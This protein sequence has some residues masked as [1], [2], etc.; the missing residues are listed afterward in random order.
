MMQL[1]KLPH[2]SNFDIGLGDFCCIEI[3]PQVRLSVERCLSRLNNMCVGCTGD[4]STWF[5]AGGYC[6]YKAGYTNTYND[7]DLYVYCNGKVNQSQN[8]TYPNMGVITFDGLYCTTQ[9]IR[10]NF[11]WNL[12]LKSHFT[13]LQ[14]YALHVIESFDL[15]ICRV[16]LKFNINEP[17]ILPTYAIDVAAVANYNNPSCKRLDKYSKRIVADQKRTVPSLKILAARVI[18]KIT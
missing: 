3:E 9:I 14:L 10:V 17:N 16:V 18:L 1:D 7:I 2:H 15:P 4:H 12:K 11:E 13:K 5:I 8:L 6:A